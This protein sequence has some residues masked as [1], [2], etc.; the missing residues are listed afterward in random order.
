MQA[1][2]AKR[3]LERR[4][5]YPTRLTSFVY[6]YFFF[7]PCWEPDYPG[8][9]VR[10]TEFLLCTFTLFSPEREGEGVCGRWGAFN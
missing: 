10:N 3:G 6:L 8:Y 4:K 7:H 1:E 5:S 9:G 2:L